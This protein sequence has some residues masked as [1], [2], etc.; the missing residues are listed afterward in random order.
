[1]KDVI[2]Q[3]HLLKAPGPNG[4]LT[5]FFNKYWRIVGSNVCKLAL[6]IINNGKDPTHIHNTH[7]A[8]IPKSKNPSSPKAFRRISLCNMVMKAITKAIANRMKHILPEV[9]DEKQ[10][11]FF[12]GRLT[13]VNA[14]IDM[15]CFHWMEKKTKGKKEMMALKLDMSKA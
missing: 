9:V 5:L 2:F 7:I 8:I 14:F 13:I 1:M 3:M 4:L 15:E 12:K 10:S 6:D 11:S